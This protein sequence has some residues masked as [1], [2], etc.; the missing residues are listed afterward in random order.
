MPSTFGEWVAED[1]D[2]VFDSGESTRHSVLTAASETSSARLESPLCD[3]TAG[4]GKGF[5]PTPLAKVLS[6]PTG[7]G[8]NPRLVVRSAKLDERW[9]CL[10]FF[11]GD[12]GEP[13][14]EVERTSWEELT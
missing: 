11:L 7:S 1:G 14:A 5:L 6:V 10:P 9:L 4:I 2:C 13:S 12:D 3:F 8:E